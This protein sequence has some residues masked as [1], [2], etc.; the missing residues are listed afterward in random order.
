MSV[1]TS[2]D[3]SLG[4]LRSI[5]ES[6]LDPDYATRAD[7]VSSHAT[8]AIP[9]SVRGRIA[10]TLVIALTMAVLVGGIASL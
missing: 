7:A 2:I 4:M 3:P 10:S 5:A 9:R 1:R 6:A 8:A